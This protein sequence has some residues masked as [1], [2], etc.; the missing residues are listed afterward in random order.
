M[1]EHVR[2]DFA[3]LAQNNG[4]FLKW[5]EAGFRLLGVIKKHIQGVFQAM[6]R[7]GAQGKAGV[8]NA[9]SGRACAKESIQLIPEVD[10]AA[11]LVEASCIGY[12]LLQ[13]E[14]NGSSVAEVN[15]QVNRHGFATERRRPENFQVRTLGFDD[16]AVFLQACF[17][18]QGKRMAGQ[19]MRGSREIGRRCSGRGLAVAVAAKGFLVARLGWTG[20]NRQAPTGV[21]EIGLQRQPEANGVAFTPT[22]AFAAVAVANPGFAGPGFPAAVV[23]GANQHLAQAGVEVRVDDLEPLF[24]PV[25]VVFGKDSGTDFRRL[26]VFAIEGHRQEEEMMS[27]VAAE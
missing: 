17:Q 9:V 8:D 18:P 24:I 19:I 23:I 12:A 3:N 10:G 14:D 6:E 1:Y 21:A 13:G 27:R 26:Q 2:G 25:G 7:R 22:S 15:D 16:K 11:D 20:V 4:F 5:P